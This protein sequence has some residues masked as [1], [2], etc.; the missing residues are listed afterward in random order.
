M[1]GSENAINVERLPFDGTSRVYVI[2]AGA[3]AFAGYPVANDLLQFI[4]DFR[5]RQASTRDLAARVLE[6]LGE[7][8]FHFSR[9][10]IRDPNGQANLEALL[11]YLELYHSFPG[12]IFDS[13]PW[14]GSDSDNVRLVIAE[15][16]LD[17]QHDLNTVT[18]GNGRPIESVGVNPTLVHKT[19]DAWA[20]RVQPGDVIITF[21]WD[22]LHEV[23]LWNS[24]LWS[25]RDGYGFLP[26]TQGQS[27]RRTKVLLLKLHGSVNWVQ[28]EV[29]KP[30]SE[31]ANVPDFFH[32]AMD[33][34]WRPHHDQA[35]ADSGRKLIL[36]TY[37]KDVSSNSVLLDLWA[38]AHR[39]ISNAKELIVIG[40]SLHPVDQPVRLLMG[41][42]LSQN[43]S[44][45]EVTVVSLDA[46]HWASFL[47]SVGKGLSHLRRRFEE[48]V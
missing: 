25:Y 44:L 18:W 13:S 38:Q 46:T 39:V 5:T 35:Q 3:S 30:V 37:L 36:P 31:I 8:Q 4:R 7:A 32:G 16:F 42:A 20:S 27:E 2:G 40:Y 48:W 47:P 24:S 1:S 45:K 12:T 6:K 15:R 22:V 14:T 33:F 19:S 11:T 28:G 26:G 17:Y 23:I 29:W 34:E 21:N 41:T 9:R 10:I 43:N